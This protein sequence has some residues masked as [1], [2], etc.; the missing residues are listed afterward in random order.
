[1][2][3]KPFS[4]YLFIFFLFF[5]NVAHS[6]NNDYIY[7]QNTN[8]GVGLFQLPSARVSDDGEFVFGITS[9]SPY[10]KI[11]SRVQMFPGLEAVLKYTEITSHPYNSGSHQ[12]WKD[13]GIDFKYRLF[14]E[15][16]NLPAIAIGLNDFGGTGAFASE[17]I[18]ASKLIN[19]FDFTL[20]LGWGRLA[21]VDHIQNPLGIF[22]DAKKKRGGFARGGGRLSIDNFFSG[23]HASVFAG[24]EYFTPIKN[25]SL[26]MEY[27]TSDYSFVDGK[28]LDMFG[29]ELEY[30]E[31][32]SRLNYGLSYTYEISEKD[33][34]NL[35]LG[36]LRGNMLFFSGAVNT[37]LNFK[38]EPRYTSPAE[39]LEK[40]Y[41]K[42]YESLNQAWKDYLT[43]LI[44]WQFGNVGFLTHNIVFDNE[45]LIVELSSTRFKYMEPAI[46]LALRILANNSPK[47]IKKLT[48]INLDFGLETYR[49][50]ISREKLVELAKLG[51]TDIENIEFEDIK[52]FSDEAIVVENKYLYPS[53]YYEIVPHLVGTIQHQEKFYFWGLDT[54]LR[55][56]VGIRKGLFLTTN[57][58]FRITDNF[59]DYDY[60]IPD[61]KLHHVRQDRRLYLKQGDKGIRNM[62]LD[63]FFSLHPDIYASLHVGILE[64][65]FGGYGG[66]I[67][68]KPENKHWAL[69]MD[70]YWVKQREFDQM[71]DFRWYETVTGFL[72]FYYDIP[73]YDLRLKTKA[74]AFLGK[75]KGVEVDISRRF[76]S[77]ARVGA[78]VALTDCNTICV[79]EGSFGKWIYFQ[80]PMDAFYINS[81]TRKTTGYT[82]SPLT[83]DAGARLEVFDLFDITAD[84]KDRIDI[85]RRKNWSF[86]KIV[87]GFSTTPVNKEWD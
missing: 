22:S 29:D 79:G 15:T 35:N 55:T 10:H 72:S 59:E 73:F 78:R 23:E 62:S 20:G 44:I 84:A 68:Y 50:S 43:N 18:V 33:S 11:F 25:L 87:S 5:V 83:K 64:W 77:G 74:G 32:D 48:V 46:D 38:S 30:F 49:A 40:A 66:Q 51:P 17:Y 12:T 81:S 2:N 39:T 80:L 65:M 67:L 54:T 42:P 26:K 85:K 6:Q 47:N 45:E 53:F 24:V 28:L 69:G 71:F 37:N 86:K 4:F 21:G 19:D 70:A 27:D 41:L 13:K 34:V 63:Y 82:W 16:Q 14:N 57:I 9:E 1:M 31:L 7:S 36:F 58:G 3:I 75:D 56:E 61:G 76:K 8:G 52:S 60:H